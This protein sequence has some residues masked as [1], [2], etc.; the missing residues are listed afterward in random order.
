MDIVNYR[1]D[2]ADRIVSEIATRN[3]GRL[4]RNAEELEGCFERFGALVKWIACDVLPEPMLRGGVVLMPDTRRSGG[5]T[6]V[7]WLAH[8]LA[9]VVLAWE[10]TRA[11]QGPGWSGD[12]HRIAGLVERRLARAARSRGVMRA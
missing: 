9:E 1:E 10:G 12:R 5:R 11:Y 7:R 8:E 6:L 2:L 3:G 4:P